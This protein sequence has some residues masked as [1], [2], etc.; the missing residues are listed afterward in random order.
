[1]P[2]PIVSGVPDRFPM[3]IFETG[4][5]AVSAGTAA[6]GWV[7][8]N[9]ASLAASASVTAL[10]DL[11]QDWNQY[12]HVVIAINPSGPSSG[13]TVTGITGSDTSTANTRRPLR[14]AD[15][16]GFG[17]ITALSVPTAGGPLAGIVH[18]LGR[19]MH[20]TVANADAVNAQGATTSITIGVR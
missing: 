14:G 2:A 6:G 15:G 18:P 19:Y 10:F 4:V 12:S 13:L 5:S 9:P 16:A 8:G 17:A 3:K 1:M 11:G 7:S 20:V